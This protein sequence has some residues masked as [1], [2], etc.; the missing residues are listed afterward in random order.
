MNAPRRWRRVGRWLALATAGAAGL[1]MLAAGVLVAFGWCDHLDA[2]Q[3]GL[4]LGNAVEADGRPSPRLRARLDAAVRL[5][6]L[7]YF[8]PV[9]V[10][11]GIDP[12]G[13]DEAAVMRDYLV[14]QGVPTA[15]ILMDNRGADTYESARRT[16]EIMREHRW[17]RVCVVSQY[18]HVP[19]ARM[20]LARCGVKH[21]ASGSAR[22][23]EWRDLYS[24][25][26]EVIGYVWYAVRRYDLPPPAEGSSINNTPARRRAWQPPG[27]LTL[28]GPS[29]ASSS[30]R[31][32][33]TSA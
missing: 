27:R 9:I 11:G 16:A 23:A 33:S 7:G 30:D 5:R 18:F 15:A 24:I 10:S 25:P 13:H 32:R 22:F 19:R 20:A 28:A 17:K 4:V 26:R 29:S 31:T 12:A 1:F 2:S 3:V 14:E 6:R 21:V 8:D